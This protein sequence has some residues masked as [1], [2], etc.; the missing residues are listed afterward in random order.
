MTLISI[1]TP[2]WNGEKFI[3]ETLKSIYSQSDYLH[4]HI[5]TD[6]MS[7]DSTP[8]IIDREKIEKTIH[9]REKDNGLYDGMNQGIDRC[10][11]DVIGIINADDRLNTGALKSIV[12]AFQDPSIDYV[13]SAVDLIDERG[14]HVGIMEPL[15]IL[16]SPPV[17]PFGKD[18][19]FYTPFPHPSLFVRKRLYEQLGRYETQYRRSAD[20]DFMAKLIHHK[21]IGLRLDSRLATFRL[22]GASSQDTSIFEEDAKIAIT[23]GM[24]WLLAVANKYKCILGRR[25]R[26]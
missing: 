4:E 18:W 17:L 19:R 1:I 23:Y 20:H 10:T 25:V 7:A 26:G 8:A 3:G 22:G 6:S 13:F 9:V 12:N 16:A 2:V 11:G 14:Q 24:P 21:K 15:P 5:I